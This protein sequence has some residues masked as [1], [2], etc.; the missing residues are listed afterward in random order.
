MKKQQFIP[1]D[2]NGML[3]YMQVNKANIYV[4][5]FNGKT[6]RQSENN[7]QVTNLLIFEKTWI[8]QNFEFWANTCFEMHGS[9]TPQPKTRRIEFLKIVDALGLA[10]YKLQNG[11]YE[12]IRWLT[13]NRNYSDFEK[14]EKCGGTRA[15]ALEKAVCK[16]LKY[17]WCGGLR[18]SAEWTTILYE[19]ENTGEVC[20]ATIP[21]KDVGRKVTPDGWRSTPQGDNEYLEVKCVCGR[22]IKAPQREND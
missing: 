6:K 2:K 13:L 18:H 17:K 15:H 5:A 7:E 19:D 11:N 12:G 22:F 4:L 8:E 20:E 21:Q 9:D 16:A 10:L 3:A 1:L 14:S